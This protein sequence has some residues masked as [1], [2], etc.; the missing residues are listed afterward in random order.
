M[1]FD[2]T[3][4]EMEEDRQIQRDR[5]AALE[6]RRDFAS[7]PGTREMLQ[8]QIRTQSQHLFDIDTVLDARL[9]SRTCRCGLNI[10]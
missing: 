6:T 10:P 8:F 3:I 7:T 1:C 2:V 4:A 5:L 9:K